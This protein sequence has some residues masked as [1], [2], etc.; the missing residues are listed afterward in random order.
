[1]I[2]PPC[3]LFPVRRWSGK[4]VITSI[5]K[6]LAYGKTGINAVGKCKLSETVWGSAHRMEGAVVLRDNWMMTG[7]L[8]KGHIGATEF[9]L[10]HLFNEAYG[11]GKCSKLIS[12]LARICTL[13]LQMHGFTCGMRDLILSPECDQ[14]RRDRIEESLKAGIL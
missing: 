9:G 10:F 6:S 5:L 7:V 1:V 8:D 4:Q 3:I 14:Q 12:S 13:Y 2:V 11:P